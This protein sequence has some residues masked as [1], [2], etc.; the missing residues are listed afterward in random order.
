M[1]LTKYS[2]PE[3]SKDLNR[4]LRKFI[5]DVSSEFKLK[6]D[7]GISAVIPIAPVA[8]NTVAGSVTF[9]NGVVTVYVAPHT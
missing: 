3:E 1:S 7:K 6:A 4:V 5:D 2:L 9:V 8:P